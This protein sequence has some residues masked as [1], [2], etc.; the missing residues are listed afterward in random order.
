MED[1]KQP[2]ADKLN[3]LIKISIIV[4]IL[5]ISCS[6]SYY[7]IIFLPQQESKRINAIKQKE[8]ELKQKERIREVNLNLC[9]SMADAEYGNFIKSYTKGATVPMPI[10]LKNTIIK[11]N[12]DARKDCYEKYPPERAVQ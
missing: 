7:F 4:S 10:E 12:K 2:L 8:E 11:R 3:N 1:N 6:V 9:L 5:L